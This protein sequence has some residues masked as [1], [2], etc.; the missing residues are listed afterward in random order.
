MRRLRGWHKAKPG[1]SQLW[2]FYRLCQDGKHKY[3]SFLK[4]LLSRFSHF[5]FVLFFCVIRTVVFFYFWLSEKQHFVSLQTRLCFEINV[6]FSIFLLFGRSGQNIFSYLN[7]PTLILFYYNI[8]SLLNKVTRKNF[9]SH[10]TEDTFISCK[11][12]I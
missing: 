4:S 7:S 11:D 8:T 5:D 3:N 1:L 12:T 10:C 6:I 2:L 9:I